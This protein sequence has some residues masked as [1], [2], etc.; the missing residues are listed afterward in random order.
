MEFEQG[1]PDYPIWVGCFPGSAAEVPALAVATPAVASPSC[2]RPPAST[3]SPCPT[4]P[5]RPGGI[6]FKSTLGAFVSVS[7]AGIVLNNGKGAV[8]TLTGPAV[9][10][11]GGAL[12]VK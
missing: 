7:D 12:I 8:I 4:C 5:G 9:S 6:L 10:V 3:P 1:D 2:C 11:N